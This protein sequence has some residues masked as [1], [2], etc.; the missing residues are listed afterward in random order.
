MFESIEIQNFRSLNQLNIEDL[1]QFNLI[2]GNTN[3]GKTSILESFFIAT[4]PGN[5]G[6][7]YR[8]NE[9]RDIPPIDEYVRTFFHF[10]NINKHIKIKAISKSK[11]IRELNI[12]PFIRDRFRVKSSE[13]TEGISTTS[14]LNKIEGLIDEFKI[15]ELCRFVLFQLL[16]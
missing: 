15:I 4:A 6:L 9:I 8:T 5:L 12:K 7:L 14:D 3:V 16:Y 2:I 10:N 11:E 1:K 13:M